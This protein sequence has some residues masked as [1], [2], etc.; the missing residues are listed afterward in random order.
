MFT[1]TNK[2][3][4]F[5][6]T[7]IV[8]GLLGIAYGFYSAPSTIEESKEI[9]A[10]SHHNDGHALSYDNHSNEDKAHDEYGN[11]HQMSHDEHVF[12]QLANRPWAALYVAA[13]F[14][15]MISLGTLAFYAIQRA[16][17]SGWSP[18]L[19][20]VMEGI[21]AYLLPG[22]LF[23]LFILILSAMSVVAVAGVSKLMWK[24]NSNWWRLRIHGMMLMLLWLVIPTNLPGLL[25]T[26]TITASGLVE[27]IGWKSFRAP[28]PTG[29]GM[30]EILD[31][32]QNKEIVDYIESK[33]K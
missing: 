18:V 17:Q 33:E 6:I 14:F 32:L 12:H 28:I 21:T 11:G 31:Y 9:V 26:L 29:Y 3:K 20:R 2:I 23:V 24:G 7:L 10:S 15:F 4:T 1:L 19:F 13:F 30:K 8:L 27:L 25:F 22:G 5:S 16:S